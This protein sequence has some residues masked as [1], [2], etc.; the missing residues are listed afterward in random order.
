MIVKEMP[1]VGRMPEMRMIE[2]FCRAGRDSEGL[3]AIWIEGEAGI[4][5]S[6]LMEEATGAVAESDSLLPTTVLYA[7]IYPDSATSLSWLLSG[8]IR[9]NPIAGRLLKGIPHPTIAS[10]TTA[11]AGLARLRPTLIVLEDLHLLDDAGVDELARLAH[12]LADIPVGTLCFS[13]PG[14]NRAFNVLAPF[15]TDSTT[16]APLSTEDIGEMMERIGGSRPSREHS[17]LLR[18]ASRGIPLLLPG[19]IV[20]YLGSGSDN[21][22]GADE[23]GSAGRSGRIRRRAQSSALSLATG[24]TD[25]LDERERNAARSLALLGQLLSVEA[26]RLILGDDADSLLDRLLSK[27]V[28]IRPLRTV[29]PMTGRACPSEI[30]AFAHTVLYD[31]LRKGAQADAERLAALIDRK[32]PLYSTT[33]LHAI[34]GALSPEAPT[35]ELYPYIILL[36]SAARALITNNLFAAG[37]TL[38]S[39]LTDVVERADPTRFDT[40]RQR[41][42]IVSLIDLRV[43]SVAYRPFSPECRTAIDDILRLTDAPSSLDDAGHRLHALCFDIPERRA[44]VYDNISRRLAE[45]ERLAATFPELP[46]HRRLHDL[47]TM[48]GNQ[49]RINPNPEQV[50]HIRRWY[51]RI[52]DHMQ[53][54]RALETNR[55]GEEHRHALETAAALLPLILDSDDLHDRTQLA[56]DVLN[57]FGPALLPSLQHSYIRFL[58]VTGRMI[59]AAEHLDRL[60]DDAELRVAFQTNIRFQSVMIDAALG[61]PVEVTERRLLTVIE[62]WQREQ[63][64]GGRGAHSYLELGAALS[65]VNI[66]F[67][68]GNEAW[69]IAL[70]RRLVGKDPRLEETIAMNTPHRVLSEATANTD[71]NTIGAES[72]PIEFRPL[73]RAIVRMTEYSRDGDSSGAVEHTAEVLQAADDALTTPII[74]IDQLD[75]LRRMTALLEAAFDPQ[76]ERPLAER[77]QS[78]IAERIDTAIDWA[79]ERNL[80]GYVDGLL[81][82]A[83]RYLGRRKLRLLEE[84][85]ASLKTDFSRGMSWG[86]GTGKHV[87]R[88]ELS[89]IGTIR[90]RGV[91]GNEFRIQG[92]KG[93]RMLGAMVL[94][95]IGRPGL[96]VEEFRRI[97]TDIGPGEGDPANAVRHVVAR[98]RSV[99]GKDSILTDGISPPR[100][101]LERVSIDLID[102]L[103]DLAEA[104]RAVRRLDARIAVARL[105]DVLSAL[106]N[107]PIL[108]ALFGEAF[109]SAR[110]DVEIRLRNSLLAAARLQR[111]AGDDE[112]AVH[113]L[114]RG[115]ERIPHDEEIMEDLAEA[116]K[117]LGRKSEER[118]IRRRWEHEAV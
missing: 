102:V 96:T 109:D 103:A 53:L 115:F 57:G 38:L 34:L 66:G 10:V 105:H 2:A 35:E 75:N 65:A 55:L 69:G 21:R 88:L 101:N 100:L 37:S 116:L 68:T 110:D 76:S 92:S 8:S 11:V 52:A 61:G 23:P 20:E 95:E 86:P 49:I 82:M 108:P 64:T 70:A 33:A 74:H 78:R 112:T 107:D 90:A 99:L 26:A 94:N 27:R 77:M 59:E 60:G 79:L 83:H 43:R 98:L 81:P 5:K 24:L 91:D 39:A 47:L 13:R 85:A 63:E 50:R 87:G 31:E 41:S 4:G 19:L 113:L 25:R 30:L 89:M 97:A 40:I 62:Q 93:R 54:R 72:M 84:R 12:S 44:D 16:L 80:H 14:G 67:L 15:L 71:N 58:M 3:S 36:C 104:D 6:R 118:S 18:D 29:S 9:T 17:E 42:V 7:T 46:G 51:G 45:I 1:F 117:R 22:F 28:L 32:V 73:F 56:Q 48:L 114:R 106:G 111:H